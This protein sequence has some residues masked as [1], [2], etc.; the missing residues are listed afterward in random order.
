MSDF[1][2][3]AARYP[4]AAA[5]LHALIGAVPWPAPAEAKGKSEAWAQQHVRLSCSKHFVIDQHGNKL[6]A[7]AWRNNVGATPAKTEHEC[8]RCSCRFVEKQT[9]IRYGLA[10]DSAV[11]NAAIKSSDLILAIPR[12]IRPADVGSTIAQF[13]SIET[14]RPGWK[15]TGKG[16]EVGQA[17]WLALINKI[18]G[19]ATF[20]TGEAEI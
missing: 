6:H 19:F 9:P 17:K 5:E 7:M 2:A 20:S 16:Q 10:N 3:W 15:Y 8:P 18:G 13:G 12:V 14:K 11:L 1:N 4:Q